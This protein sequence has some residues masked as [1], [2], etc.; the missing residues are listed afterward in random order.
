MYPIELVS[1]RGNLLYI[2]YYSILADLFI[3]V[4]LTN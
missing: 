3:F 1:V 4:K 2:I